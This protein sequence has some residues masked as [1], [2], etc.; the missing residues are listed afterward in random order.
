[1]SV[2]VV[3][4]TGEPVPDARVVWHLGHG[5]GTAWVPLDPRG[6]ATLWAPP[7]EPM[8]LRPMGSVCGQDQAMRIE[9]A[10]TGYTITL[11]CQ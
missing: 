3:D 2:E 6:R 7:G 8:V 11:K 1:M 9:D 5:L 4:G 10:K